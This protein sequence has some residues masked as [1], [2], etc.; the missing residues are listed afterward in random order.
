[1]AV[2]DVS[3]YG[4]PILRKLTKRV[5]DFDG[6]SDLI[7]NMFDT[8]YENE[9][10]GLAA[11]QVS[12]DLRL[13]VVDISVYDEY[14]EPEVFVNGEIIESWGSSVVEEGCL[15]LPEIRVDV[16]R[17]EFIKFKYQDRKGKYQEREF[18]GLMARVIQHEMDHLNGIFIVNRI[19]PLKLIQFKKKLKEIS[20]SSQVKETKKDLSGIVL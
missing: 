19:S 2:L 18:N 16:D 12:F 15:S 13:A 17:P 4:K 3:L 10:M 8:M 20:N 9:G 6:L 7:G 11:N 1:M 14:A 5:E